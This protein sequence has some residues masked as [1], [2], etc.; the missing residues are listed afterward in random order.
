MIT[1][2]IITTVR[3]LVSHPGMRDGCSSTARTL[4]TPI[5][6]RKG[7]SCYELFHSLA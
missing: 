3:S 5:W 6:V 2:D 7:A 4:H 1:T